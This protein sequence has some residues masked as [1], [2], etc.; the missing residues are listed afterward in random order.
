MI[1]EAITFITAWVQ[2]FCNIPDI[3]VEQILWYL[4]TNDLQN[5]LEAFANDDV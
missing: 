4:T 3:C 5:I 2:Q 1:A